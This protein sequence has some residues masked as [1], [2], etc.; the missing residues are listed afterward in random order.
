MRPIH[1]STTNEQHDLT[2]NEKNAAKQEMRRRRMS[3]AEKEEPEENAIGLKSCSSIGA[4]ESTDQATFRKTLRASLVGLLFQHQRQRRRRRQ[5]QLGTNQQDDNEYDCMGEI[6]WG[7]VD[8]PSLCRHHHHHHHHHHQRQEQSL[9]PLSLSSS[10][11]AAA[12]TTTTPLEEILHQLSNVTIV[13]PVYSGSVFLCLLRVLMDCTTTTTTTTTTTIGGCETKWTANQTLLLQTM[14]MLLLWRRIRFIAE[15][16]NP[17]MEYVE[18]SFSLGRKKTSNANTSRIA[19]EAER[20]HKLVSVLRH[21]VKQQQQQQQQQDQHVWFARLV[22]K[23]LCRLVQWLDDADVELLQQ[24]QD[25]TMVHNHHVDND[26]G[27]SQ[28]NMCL[29]CH[30]PI[31][32]W[33]SHHPTRRRRRHY[34]VSLSHLLDEQHEPIENENNAQQTTTTMRRRSG[35]ATR[36]DPC[37]CPFHVRQTTSKAWEFTRIPFEGILL[38]LRI[39]QKILSTCCRPSVVPIPQQQQRHWLQ[40]KGILLR[41]LVQLVVQQPYSPCLR[42]GMLQCAHWNGMWGYT[43]ILDELWRCYHQSLSSSS[44]SS[45][46]GEG[47]LRVLA[48]TVGECRHFDN[49]TNA[50][51][52]MKPL[53]AALMNLCQEEEE[54]EEEEDEER[55][56]SDNTHH[57]HHHHDYGLLLRCFSF[58]LWRRQLHLTIPR[59]SIGGAEYKSLILMLSVRFGDAHHWWLGQDDDDDDDEK[60][61]GMVQALRSAGIL[62]F[63]DCT[64]VCSRTT[65]GTTSPSSLSGWPFPAAQSLRHAHERMG[66]HV[67]PSDPDSMLLSNHNAH[68]VD[69]NLEND[70]EIGR[71]PT[72]TTTTT[73]T[74][75]KNRVSIMHHLH[76]DVLEVMM[77]FLGYKRLCRAARVCKD[78]NRIAH[79]GNALWKHAFEGRYGIRGEAEDIAKAL[80][81]HQDSWRCVFVATWRRERPLRFKRAADGWRH[82]ICS[83]TGCFAILRTRL[84]H[85]RHEKAHNRKQERRQR[86]QQQANQE[87]KTRKRKTMTP[88]KKS[89]P[90]KR[91]N[92]KMN[93]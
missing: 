23:I 62:G 16:E 28:P 14:S 12:T 29:Q 49:P 81:T 69:C 80:A 42:L 43:V 37:T 92:T 66:P 6:L 54:E 46:V 84:Q 45:F 67:T 51:R 41:Q 77:S 72:T 73:T 33:G 27:P 57:D 35:G 36:M 10:K 53:V 25:N 19:M 20:I 58:L 91:K 82:Q 30:K 75:N 7:E 90:P 5:Q 15:I 88:T 56:S 78:W 3:A 65:A 34:T 86:R 39:Y 71:R 48:E 22:V 85:D 38:R 2:Q 74:R 89:N 47:V 44:S 63:A 64:S 79:E 24:Q 32:E 93:K 70:Q 11:A 4:Y 26:D 59:S 83:Y 9:V 60:T 8:W 76:D 40:H 52:A 17:L 55:R 50:W 87:T 21:L 61:T 68:V 1:P 31:V 13:P 18:Q